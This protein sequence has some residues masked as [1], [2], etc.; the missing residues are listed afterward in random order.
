M[1][2]FGIS[3]RE[4]S[5][6]VGTKTLLDDVSLDIERGAYCCLLGPNGAGK[7][8]LLKC[9]DGLYDTWTGT[10]AIDGNDVREMSRRALSSRLGYVPQVR[11]V[12]PDFNVEEFLMMSR[13]A[14][15]RGG[16]HERA[17][18]EAALERVGMADFRRRSMRTLS[19]GECQKVFIASGLVQ[20]TPFLLLDEPTS[21]LDPRY[22]HDVNQL[23]HDLNRRDGVT[24][25]CVSHDLNSALLYSDKLV[26][27][28]RGRV[29]FALS[30]LE[31][32]RSGRLETLFDTTFS[33]VDVPGGNGL[34]M[35]VPC[36]EQGH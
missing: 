7:S 24:I 30:P 18:V 21:F 12:P 29:E 35:I 11:D 22:Q 26:G 28:K 27:L 16:A 36:M 33:Y 34:R 20:E 2:V 8:T 25:V 15:E 32:I 14:R 5:L 17:I 9:L 6:S 4:L 19:G 1:S 31:V 23:L 3:V 10:I 13:Y